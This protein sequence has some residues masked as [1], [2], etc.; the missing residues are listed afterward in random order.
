M[1]VAEPL[2]MNYGNLTGYPCQLRMQE[3]LLNVVCVQRMH[4]KL[5][6]PVAMKSDAP[7]DVSAIVT[8]VDLVDVDTIAGTMTTSVF[9]DYIWDDAFVTWNSSYTDSNDFILILSGLLWILD[10]SI[11]NSI[12]L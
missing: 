8:F 2:D 7:V 11:Y 5:L 1:Y 3:F 4:D 6:V 10:I 12:A 9:I